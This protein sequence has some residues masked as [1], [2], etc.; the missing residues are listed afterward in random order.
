MAVELTNIKR[1]GDLW[2]KSMPEL[3]RINRS[4]DRAYVGRDLTKTQ[5]IYQIVYHADAPSLNKEK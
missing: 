5:L 2:Q 1:I 3:R 4:D